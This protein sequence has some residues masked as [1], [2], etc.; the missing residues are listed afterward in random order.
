[1]GLAQILAAG[2]DSSTLAVASLLASGGAFFLVGRILR[3]R[4]ADASAGT[5]SSP[6]EARQEE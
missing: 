1:M 5:Y 3:R 2:L 4:Y 6:E